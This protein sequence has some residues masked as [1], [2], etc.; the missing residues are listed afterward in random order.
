MLSFQLVFSI[1]D[2]TDPTEDT[3]DLFTLD[4]SL[5]DDMPIED[6]DLFELSFSQD[7]DQ[8]LMSSP[9]LTAA[10]GGSCTVGK[11]RDGASCSV[12]L[13]LEIPNV[14]DVFGIGDGSDDTGPD[15]RSD[16]NTWDW[17]NIV[18]PCRLEAPYIIHLCCHGPLGPRYGLGWTG[19]DKCVPGAYALLHILAFVV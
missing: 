6:S 8:F 10:D 19:L 7:S 15:S 11:K 1:P 2:H 18:N 16:A 14:L 3:T 13:T 9:E 4:N 17:S 12:P 5:L